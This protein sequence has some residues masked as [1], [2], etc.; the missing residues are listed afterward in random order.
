MTTV[1]F[2]GYSILSTCGAIVVILVILA[3][4]YYL[5]R[6]LGYCR[7]TQSVA[8]RVQTTMN[9]GQAANIPYTVEMSNRALDTDNYNRWASRWARQSGRPTHETRHETAE[10]TIVEPRKYSGTLG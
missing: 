7:A 5:V 9:Q 8:S 1:S 4:L 3:L 6:S 10:A 2:H